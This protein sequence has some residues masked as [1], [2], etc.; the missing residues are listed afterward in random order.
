MACAE[1]GCGA[2]DKKS[3]TGQEDGASS[4]VCRHSSFDKK[5]DILL[6][7]HASNN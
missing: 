7:E 2:L 3:A 1:G 4:L 6:L 5:H